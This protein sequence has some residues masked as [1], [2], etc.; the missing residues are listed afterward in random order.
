[1]AQGKRIERSEE[2]KTLFS[3]SFFLRCVAWF[4]T[5]FFS[6]WVVALERK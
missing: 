5:A 4:L 2:A 6:D 3:L 1:M